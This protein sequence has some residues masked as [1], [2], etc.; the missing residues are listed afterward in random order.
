MS[1][2]AFLK[3][4]GALG[5]SCA[6]LAL[7]ATTAVA[8]QAD[9]SKENAAAQ[10]ADAAAGA[11]I[12]PIPDYTGDVSERSYLSG[13]WGGTR[14]NLANRGLQVDLDTV[15]WAHSFVDGGSRDDTRVGGNLTFNLKWDLMRAG[16]LPGALITL[17]AES[18][19]GNSANFSV[20]QINFPSVAAITPTN[21]SAPDDGY[22]LSVTQLAYTQ[23]LSEKAGF[24]IGKFDLF[25]EGDANEFAG[26]RGRTQFSNW[27]LNYGM[28]TLIVPSSTVGLGAIFLPSENTTITALLT[29][30][31]ECVDSNCF[32]DLDDQGKIATASIAHQYNLNGKPGGLN[33]QA[34]YLF[35]ND[36]LELNSLSFNLRDAIRGGSL[37]E[38]FD[39]GGKDTSWIVG[40]SFWQYLSVK[41]AAP[42][43][44][45][46]LTNKVPDLRGWGVFGRL[47]F[48]DKDTNPWKTTVAVGLGGRG[49][50]DSRPDDLFG[51]GYYYN[52]QSK[53]L[54]EPGVDDGQGAEVFYNFAI[55]PA[56]RFTTSAQWIKAVSP[57]VDNTTL[58]SARL[59]VTF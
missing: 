53:T 45:L 27:S 12:L 36:F 14:T 22:N 31:T 17:R 39:F 48:A 18:R 41:G 35:D 54:F 49:L 6:A 19:W 3:N 59:Q 58:V 10:P 13:D 4:T 15:T 24:T 34:V 38:G 47:Y 28:P 29:S 40:G 55:T 51:V 26:G 20:G 43:G 56:A 8:Q 33:G 46:N 32:D 23:F 52:D 21:Y 44:P 37:R 57:T 16:I 50:F 7:V 2:R 11:G 30:G 1:I 25:G 42:Q 5:A 9:D